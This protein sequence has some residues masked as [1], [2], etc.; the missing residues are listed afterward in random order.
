MKESERIKRLT[1][2]KAIWQSGYASKG[3]KSHEAFLEWQAQIAPLLNFNDFYYSNFQEFASKVHVKGLSTGMY[4]YLLS[5]LDSLVGQAVAELEHR[6][7]QPDDIEL[8][9]AHGLYWFWTHATNKT[10]M[11][12]VMFIVGIWSIGLALGN[13]HFFMEL[14]NLIKRSIKS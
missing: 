1:A 5:V 6:L 3:F 13:S 12:L 7:T 2:I 4:E 8:G 10:K 14:Y 9:D 11:W